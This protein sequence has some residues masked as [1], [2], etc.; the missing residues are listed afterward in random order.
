MNKRPNI[1]ITGVSTGIGLDAAEHLIK[2]GYHVFGSV[3]KPADAKRVQQALGEHFTPLLFDVTDAKAITTAVEQVQ[4]Q[5]GDAGLCALV[6]NSGV[7]GAAP[8]MYEPVDDVRKMFEVNVFGLLQVTQAFLPLLGARE[9]CPHAPGRLINISSIS[10]GLVFPFVGAYGG[11]KHA[12][13]AFSD[14]LRRELGIFGIKVIAIE[15]GNIR[16]PIWEKSHE[17]DQRFAATAYASHMAKMPAILAKMGK[18]GAPP[19]LVSKTILRAIETKRPK[20]RYPLTPLW[21]LSRVLGD[22]ALDLLT[23][24][25]MGIK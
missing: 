14:A 21:R 22:G 19:E 2:Q 3:R 24:A 20:T 6:N 1:L 10:G 18:N 8:L 5:V 9:N 15:P 4:Q 25:A 13:E 11:S 12:V 16:T 7:S 23:K 17:A